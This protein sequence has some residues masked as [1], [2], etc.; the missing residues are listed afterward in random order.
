MP[1]P[2]TLSLVTAGDEKT[3]ALIAEGLVKEKL[4]ACVSV[5]G[6]LSSVY[7]WRDKIE[8][9]QEFLLLIK[10]RENL[11]ED[12]EQFV[13]RSHNYGTPEIL[14]LNIGRGSKEYLDWLGANTLFTTN[15]PRDKAEKAPR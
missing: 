8:K 7:R 14:F 15:I 13:K 10:T 3:A 1:T 11:C 6:G 4:A 9:K 2:Y 12:V 5:I